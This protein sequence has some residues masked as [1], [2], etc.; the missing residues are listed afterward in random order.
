MT[1]NEQPSGQTQSIGEQSLRPTRPAYRSAPAPAGQTRPIPVPSKPAA[2]PTRSDQVYDSDR[3]VQD[4][5]ESSEHS[6]QAGDRRIIGPTFWTVAAIV[7]LVLDV[8]LI[9][10]ILILGRQLSNLRMIVAKDLASGLYTNF[11]KMDQAHI[12]TTVNVATTVQVQDQIPVVFNLPLNE[13]TNVVLTEPTS[14]NSAT[15]I[16]NGAIV[17][18]SLTLPGGT[19]LRID[20]DMVIPVSTTVP[21]ALD[22]PVNVVVPVDIP[23]NQ[24]ELHESIVGLQ[25]V[26]APESE[27]LINTPYQWKE[28]SACNHWYS[29]W[30]CLI[31]FGEN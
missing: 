25:S 12:L 27:I 2:S 21:I 9:A 19:S 8:I 26:F 16:L 11:A 6:R 18:T 1:V 22:V 3:Q 20:M 17:P 7:S 14:I 15:I 31:V 5:H 29:R 24:T 28:L 13:K 23:V 4:Y 10:I 30:M